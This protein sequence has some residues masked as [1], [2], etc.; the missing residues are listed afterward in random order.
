MDTDVGIYRELL[1]SYHP[2]V[3]V[4]TNHVAERPRRQSALGVYLARFP[5]FDEFYIAIQILAGLTDL[6]FFPL[7]GVC[8]HK[9]QA[10]IR[11][12][13][14]ERKGAVQMQSLLP[15]VFIQHL[16]CSSDAVAAGH[17][18]ID[19]GRWLKD[20]V[21]AP[22]EL[23]DDMG[24]LPAVNGEAETQSLAFLQL[25]PALALF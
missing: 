9:R 25:I 21:R 10:D 17:E 23:S 11:L 6:F 2:C 1:V 7:W 16:H 14:D 12:R 20:D 3:E 15:K 4:S 18:R 24:W 5:F 13:H 8:V 19:E 22:Y